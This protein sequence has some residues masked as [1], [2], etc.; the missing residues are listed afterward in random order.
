MARFKL[1][2]VCVTC[3]VNDLMTENAEFMKFVHRCFTRFTGCDWG[4]MTESDR[5]QNEEALKHNDNRLFA[6]YEHAEHPDWRLWIITECDRS[7][8][9][10]LFPSEY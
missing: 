6:A 10:A 7:A 1:G 4:D 3:G 9:T 8:T 2:K 5:R